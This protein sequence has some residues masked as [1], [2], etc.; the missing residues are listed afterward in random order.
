G[1][2]AVL[3]VFTAILFERSYQLKGIL[4]GGIYCAVALTALF[5]SMLATAF[6]G[7]QY[8]YPEEQVLLQLML[9][10]L[11]MTISILTSRL[12]LNKKVKVYWRVNMTKYLKLMMGVVIIIG[13]IGTFYIQSV[14]ASHQLPKITLQKKSGEDSEVDGLVIYGVYVEKGS[15][16][17]Y[18][19]M[20]KED[21][22]YLNEH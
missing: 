16:E 6:I 8:L 1:F 18:F 3:I 12:L 13:T 21:T 20:T 9:S 14:I 11:V 5:S 4:F 17:H 2:I 10:V 15:Q 19:L 7:V 22:T